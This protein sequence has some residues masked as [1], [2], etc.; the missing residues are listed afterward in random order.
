MG[1]D[2]IGFDL[3]RKG[4]ETER[5]RLRE[6]EGEVQGE[7]PENETLMPGRD[8]RQTEKDREGERRLTMRL[9]RDPTPC[10]T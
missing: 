7:N 9:L 2:D 3:G 1:I 10:T 5:L 6:G 4:R 8:N